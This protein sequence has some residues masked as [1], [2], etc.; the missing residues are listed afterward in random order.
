MEIMKIG[1]QAEHCALRWRCKNI[2]K[3]CC[4]TRQKEDGF[5][6]C[7]HIKLKK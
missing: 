5:V 6:Y 3:K 7:K 1:T 2:N 4:D